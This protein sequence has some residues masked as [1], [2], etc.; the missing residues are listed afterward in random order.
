MVFAYAIKRQIRGYASNNTLIVNLL[1]SC[2]FCISESQKNHFFA[3]HNF[4]I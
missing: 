2:T 3:V 4:P 1:L